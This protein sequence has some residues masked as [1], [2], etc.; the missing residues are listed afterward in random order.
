MAVLNE[1][2]GMMIIIPAAQ[3]DLKL[4]AADKGIIGAM[5]FL[6]KCLLFASFLF[7]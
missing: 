3:C 2:M 7:K 4:T 6:G 1:T 5:G